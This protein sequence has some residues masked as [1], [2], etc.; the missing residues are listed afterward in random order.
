MEKS[1]PDPLTIDDLNDRDLSDDGHQFS[2][3][4]YRILSAQNLGKVMHS[5]DASEAD[6]ELHQQLEVLLASWRQNIPPWKQDSLQRDGSPDEMMFQAHMMN[7]TTS[8]LLHRSRANLDSYSTRTINACAEEEQDME[9]PPFAAV[10][11]VDQHSQHVMRSASEICKLITHRT[12]LTRHSHFFVCAV[13]LSAIVQLSVWSMQLPVAREEALRE[14]VRLCIGALQQI[15]TVWQSAMT[16]LGQIKRVAG[17]IH[18]LKKQSRQMEQ[19][20]VEVEEDDV[21]NAFGADPSL[22]G[23]MEMI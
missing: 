10:A 14:Q 8:I 22:I 13:V 2:S 21:M 12:A 9:R 20:L 7:H 11:S 23:G 17:E 18:A 4:A 3:F 19:F 6:S 15:S 16:A 5:L 1:I